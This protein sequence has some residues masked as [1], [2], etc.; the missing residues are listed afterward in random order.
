M[1]I[2]FSSVQAWRG[3]LFD[4]IFYSTVSDRNTDFFSRNS[5]GS[6]FRPKSESRI[7][8]HGAFISSYDINIQFFL[9]SK[10]FNFGIF[11]VFRTGICSRANQLICWIYRW[12][13]LSFGCFT[14]Y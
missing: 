7:R 9:F 14:L 6:I 13:L 5:R 4:T 1:E 12:V 11:D 10:V 8:K 2:P 3:S